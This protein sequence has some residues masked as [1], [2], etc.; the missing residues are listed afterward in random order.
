MKREGPSGIQGGGEERP[1]GKEGKA[2]ERRENEEEKPLQRLCVNGYIL[3]I[4]SFLFIS[5]CLSSTK[6]CRIL[7]FY[8]SNLLSP[9]PSRSTVKNNIK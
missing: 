8:Q 9:H 4:Y 2:Q 6:E 1:K 3:H 5:L 7:G